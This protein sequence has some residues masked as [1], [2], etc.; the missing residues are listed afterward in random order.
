[1]EV[2]QKKVELK[3]RNSG[4]LRYTILLSKS[5]FDVLLRVV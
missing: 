4:K 5:I 2:F 3:G 1:M